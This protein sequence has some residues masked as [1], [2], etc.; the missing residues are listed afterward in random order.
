M[1]AIRLLQ[2]AKCTRKHRDRRGAE[3]DGLS[4][5]GSSDRIGLRQ[6]VDTQIPRC[7]DADAEDRSRSMERAVFVLS[8]HRH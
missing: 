6:S 4:R 5:I 8:G 7:R 3:E 2:H 1:D